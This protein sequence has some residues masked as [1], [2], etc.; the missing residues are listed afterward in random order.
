MGF[1]GVMVPVGTW[2]CDEDIYPGAA[3]TDG[4]AI[5]S[6]PWP[7]GFTA[8][9]HFDRMPTE[10][11]LIGRFDEVAV[12]LKV[13]ARQS[14]QRGEANVRY[15]VFGVEFIL[16]Y[17]EL[18]LFDDSNATP[19]PPDFVL[20]VADGKTLK[21]TLAPAAHFIFDGRICARII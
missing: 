6:H 10:K 15:A 4:Q 13:A 7:Y 20:V 21:P 17:I 5:H 2:S 12:R 14:L 18:F 1:S 16:A 9:V 3:D 8:R 19:S 11:L